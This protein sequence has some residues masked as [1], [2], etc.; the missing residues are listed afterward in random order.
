MKGDKSHK[1]IHRALEILVNLTHR[2]A[3]GCDESTG[4]GAGI[5]LQMPHAFMTKVTGELGIKLPGEK[6][7]ASGLVF[8]PKDG[9]A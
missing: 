6:E 5:L 7:Y 8:L 4:D 9:L 1:V 3:T 2:G